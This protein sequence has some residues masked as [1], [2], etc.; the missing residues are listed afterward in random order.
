M[1]RG[2]KTCQELMPRF[3]RILFVT[4]PILL[5]TERS[6]LLCTAEDRRC[7]WNASSVHEMGPSLTVPESV[8]YIR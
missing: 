5:T 4:C 1:R 3:D 2:Q 8:Q 7:R 6:S